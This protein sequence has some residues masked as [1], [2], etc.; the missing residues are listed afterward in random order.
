MARLFVSL[1]TN[2]QNIQYMDYIEQVKELSKEQLAL[3]IGNVIN[4]ANCK[5]SSKNPVI[6]LTFCGKTKMPTVDKYI[7]KSHCL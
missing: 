7:C 4:C 5:F 6:M 3:H 2:N 1:K